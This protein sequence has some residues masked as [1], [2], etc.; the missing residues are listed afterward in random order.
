MGH[1][2]R[3][4]IRAN[5][6]IT[7]SKYTHEELNTP[8]DEVNIEGIGPSSFSQIEA[9]CQGIEG[10]LLKD[11][12]DQGIVSKDVER[13]LLPWIIVRVLEGDELKMIRIS[14][15]GARLLI[16]QIEAAL[17]GESD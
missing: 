16:A 9:Y 3:K 15:D 2:Y 8:I 10:E 7:R 5:A 4:N 11:I 6:G 14:P 13:A 12:Q 17:R 1:K